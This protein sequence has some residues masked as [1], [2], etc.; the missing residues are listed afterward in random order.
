[1]EYEQEILK[2]PNSLCVLNWYKIIQIYTAQDFFTSSWNS[3]DSVGNLFYF[4]HSEGVSCC[5]FI[6]FYFIV[7]VVLFLSNRTYQYKSLGK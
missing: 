5:Y 4:I 1:M 2:S 6:L 7:V 3:S